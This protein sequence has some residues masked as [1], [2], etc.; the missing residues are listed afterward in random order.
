MNSFVRPSL[1]IWRR[2]WLGQ[3]HFFLFGKLTTRLTFVDFF[4]FCVFFQY[5][6]FV[7]GHKLNHLLLQGNS[8]SGREIAQVFTHKERV[9]L[10]YVTFFSINLFWLDYKEGSWQQKSKLLS[11]LGSQLKVYELLLFFGISLSRSF[12]FPA[13]LVALKFHIFCLL[14]LKYYYI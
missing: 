9:P 2:F 12:G 3:T 13:R 1:P 7:F 4:H 6:F 11:L 5:F 10:F 8:L 14:L